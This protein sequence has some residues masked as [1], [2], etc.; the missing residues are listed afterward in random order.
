MVAKD[1]IILIAI[2]IGYG[3]L[4]VCIIGFWCFYNKNREK[5]YSKMI[6]KDK[7]LNYL[8]ERYNN[9]KNEYLKFHSIFKE[10]E[11]ELDKQRNL[12]PISLPEEKQEIYKNIRELKKKL[13]LIKDLQNL[14][15]NYS[16]WDIKNIYTLIIQ[17]YKEKYGLFFIKYGG[18]DLNEYL[19][20]KNE[21]E[22]NLKRLTKDDE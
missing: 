13:E 22:Q 2:I 20:W 9:N 6:N 12:I 1:I 7:T 16:K 5:K 18:W 8:I 21:Y 10:T 19:K 15:D 11:E 4:C 14:F 17:T 3:L